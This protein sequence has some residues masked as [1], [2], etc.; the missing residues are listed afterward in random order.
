MIGGLKA[1]TRGATRAAVGGLS[2]GGDPRA[3]GYRSTKARALQTHIMNLNALLEETQTEL[4]RH[5]ACL[6]FHLERVTALRTT[7]QRLEAY[8]FGGPNGH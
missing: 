1:A 2:A 3:Q 6:Q 7:K 8:I 5:A 4:D